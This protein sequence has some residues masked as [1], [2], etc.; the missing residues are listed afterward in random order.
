MARSYLTVTPGKEVPQDKIAERDNEDKVVFLL[1][2]GV[3]QVRIE[4]ADGKHMFFIFNQDEITELEAKY[5]SGEPLMVDYR[6]VREAR[7]KWRGALDMLRNIREALKARKTPINAPGEPVVVT[8]P[9]DVVIP[10]KP[11][12]G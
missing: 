3:N 4:A 5:L 8:M 12:E 11:L 6:K 1:A 7:E 10:T 9:M 2:S